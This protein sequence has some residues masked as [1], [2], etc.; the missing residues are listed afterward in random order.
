MIVFDYEVLSADHTDSGG[1]FI[2]FGWAGSVTTVQLYAA[3][4]AASSQPA[5]DYYPQTADC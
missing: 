3:A 2:G 4:L 1:V 5:A